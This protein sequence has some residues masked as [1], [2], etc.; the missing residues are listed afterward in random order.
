MRARA[1]GRN[2]LRKEGAGKVSGAAQY[3]DDIVFPDLLYARTI[4][5]TICAGEVVEVALPFDTAGFTIVDYRDIPG[6]NVIALIEDDQPCLAER[7]IRHFAEPIL[8]L[9]HADRDRLHAADVHVSYR[10][11]PPQ[12]DAEWSPKDFKRII[13]E[14]GDLEAG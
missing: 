8:L 13:I 9:A 1:V 12:F 6:K 4:R 3:I 7:H 11:A 2:V 10:E 14:K 5:S